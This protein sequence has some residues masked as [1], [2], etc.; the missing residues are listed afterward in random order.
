MKI[1]IGEQFYLILLFGLVV[2]SP[3]NFNQ[4]KQT[5]QIN[6]MN[7]SNKSKPITFYQ[8]GKILSIVSS[9]LLTSICVYCISPDENYYLLIFFSL[10]IVIIMPYNHL[11]VVRYF[12]ELYTLLA[13][14][15]VLYALFGLALFF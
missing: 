14:T 3:F 8:V 6:N 10:Y 15:L 1:Y 2:D 11:T 9:I 4:I 12:N 13:E 5:K 7:E